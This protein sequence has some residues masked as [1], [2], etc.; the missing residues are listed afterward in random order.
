MWWVQ[1]LPTY[2]QETYDRGAAVIT[3]LDERWAN[4]H[5]KTIQLLPNCIA[6]ERARRADAFEAVFVS[7]DGL[8]R[9]GTSSSFF[10]V[11]DGAL[12]THPLTHSILPSI[13]RGLLIALAR[14]SGLAVLERTIMTS[15]LSNATEAFTCST[16]TGLMPVTQ[17]DGHSVGGGAVGPVSRRLREA[18]LA[19][20]ARIRMGSS[21]RNPRQ[22]VSSVG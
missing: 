17:I 4:C 5:L 8:L 21:S 11:I 15:E 14:E 20:L 3:T 22:T 9:E 6:R 19:Y 18:F 7:R 12:H 16:T 13:T 10:V 1:A 2:P